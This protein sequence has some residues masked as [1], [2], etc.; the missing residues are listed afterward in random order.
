MP[1]RLTKSKNKSV[2]F[3]LIKLIRPKQWIK[4]AFVLAPLLFT[5]K[6]INPASIGQA[7]LAMVFFCIAASASYIINDVCDLKYDRKHPHKAKKRPIASGQ[8]KPKA[9][10]ILMGFLYV[11]IACGYFQ[12]PNVILI[13]I[14]YL[15]LNL[16][17]SFF[18][19]HQ[20]VIDIF[21]VA[22]GFVLRV[23]AG[24]TALSVPVSSWMSITTLCLA[25]H[26]AAIKRRQELGQHGKTSRGVLK[27][28]TINLID[29]YTQMTA[30]GTLLFYSLFTL[31]VRPEL[32][33]SLPF[34]LYGLFRYWFL[35][36]TL[37]S[38]EAPS[39][40]LLSDWQ[41]LL[42]VTIWAGISAWVVWP[43]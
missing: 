42:T 5:G 43:V 25:L 16:L 26:L 1:P 37:N 29:R 15:I 23:Y 6:F 28:Y 17:Y 18:L 8:V 24:A 14:A 27:Y 21:I 12:Q 36:E 9:A 22:L 35:V 10:L 30:M 41:L 33:I 2:F 4:N 32:A 13:I 20:P 34:V 11:I 31:T 19:K 40:T 7:T 38:G 39:D 3:G